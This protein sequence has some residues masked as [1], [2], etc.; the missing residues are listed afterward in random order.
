MPNKYDHIPPFGTKEYEE[1]IRKGSTV[2]EDF[3]YFHDN[4]AL[5]LGDVRDIAIEN[6]LDGPEWHE[7]SAVTKLLVQFIVTNDSIYLVSKY[8]LGVTLPPYQVLVLRKFWE[9]P[10]C[11]LVA[12]RGGSKSFL[13]AVYA[14]LRLLL[15]QGCKICVVGASLRQSLVLF[16]YIMQIWN[17][18]PILRDIVKDSPKRDINMS[19]WQVGLS[20]VIF[21]P[22]GDGETIRGQ[23]A[24]HIICDETA[25]TRK[26]T[27][28]ETSNGI[29]RIED[30]FVL[31][32][33]ELGLIN[34]DGRVVYSDKYYHTP[35]TDV[36]EV[37]TR[38]GFT[39]GCSEI[40]Q[41]KTQ[42]G[43]KL[44]K[45]LTS[46]DYLLCPNYY[47]FPEKEI[48]GIDSEMAW[49]LGILVSEGAVS[50]RHEVRVQM[51]DK[52]TVDKIADILRKHT[53]NKVSIDHQEGYIDPR[54][55]DCKEKWTV[56]ICDL[57]F[58]NK[59]ES[60]G[61]L[62]ITVHEKKIPHTILR[63]PAH[64]VKAFLSGLFLGD[65]SCY[66]W[67][68][69]NSK[70][71]NI[72]NLLGISYY[73]VSE[74]LVSEV[75]F[76]L[77]KF[78]IFAVK[79]SRKSKLSDLPQWMLRIA[80]EDHAWNLARLLDI[81]K[82]KPIIESAYVRP[83]VRDNNYCI[84]QDKS[85]WDV[86]IYQNPTK[87]VSI[88]RFKKLEDAIACRDDYFA[89]KHIPSL[90]V[91]SVKKLDKKERLY[92]YHIPD[93]HS[94]NAA[95]FI[96]HNSINPV[97]FE[98]VVRGFAAVKSDGV[99][100]N[101]QKAY[102]QELLNSRVDIAVQED[103]GLPNI[104]ESNQ[105]I[106]A[107]SAVPEFNHFYKYYRYYRD[108]ID[109]KGNAKLLK[110]MHPDRDITEDIDPKDYCV[111]HIPHDALP[112]G[113]MDK[114]ILKQ[115]QA[116]MDKNIFMMEYGA[117]FVKDTDGFIPA[118]TI[119]RATCP[120]VVGDDKIIFDIELYG[121]K[122]ARYVMGIDPASEDDNFAVSVVGMKNGRRCIVYQWT[123]N[124]KEFEQLRST[125]QVRESITDYLTFCTLHVRNLVRRFN[126]VMIGLDTGGGGLAFKEALKDKSK[127]IDSNDVFIL[128]MDDENSHELSGDTILKMIEFSHYQWRRE[129]HYGIKTDINNGIL[130]FPRYDLA[131][132]AVKSFENLA[133]G[134]FYDT[135]EDANYEIEQCK[136]ECVRIKAEQTPSGLE[137][138][139]VPNVMT[140]GANGEKVKLK[141]D[142]FT[143]LMIANWVARL[144]AERFNIEQEKATAL[145]FVGGLLQNYSQEA[146]PAESGYMMEYAGRGA[147]RIKNM[148]TNGRYLK[149]RSLGV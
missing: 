72:S 122:E 43:Y 111:M 82:W 70:H 36:Y 58:R 127:F 146:V 90:R 17:S 73:S 97:I 44:A 8:I 4:L 62:R 6:P 65:G 98:K 125:G 115:G 88:G 22:L 131:E 147:N 28:V 112:P 116:T 129:A 75:Q 136:Q 110:E 16:N 9:K 130:L 140:A 50:N 59:L 52:E 145:P 138:W 121:D 91:V 18:A 99:W 102:S 46:N 107:G 33:E 47:K 34:E 74:Q 19:Y 119:Y 105:I 61:L 3:D 39:F 30:T 108:I 14:I 26:G 143:S 96:Q 27:L 124:R 66:H 41:V 126:P 67:F 137:K 24:T 29:Y 106:M 71:E 104:L 2:P 37:K 5:E 51:T 103:L 139:D 141:K 78:N 95:G 77:R 100:N 92:D 83:V 123:T 84:I 63:S 56:R 144:A 114:V 54:G 40:H 87:N 69:K 86:R 149:N 80:A 7:E 85:G 20:R 15:H 135:L 109:T 134:R 13:L 132:G 128:D 64:I 117:C 12:T 101:I 35:E 53:E 133:M 120:M 49:L 60:W 94:F 76:L 42:N 142:R 11:L 79:C 32:H 45:D 10:L 31:K 148:V 93:S 113:M 55:W 1:I 25:C 118:S 89:N 23:R 68:D 21:L 57:K 38:Y 48:E 81:P